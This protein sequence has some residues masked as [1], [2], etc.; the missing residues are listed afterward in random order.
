MRAGG[1]S[2][3]IGAAGVPDDPLGTIPALGAVVKRTRGVVVLHP[4]RPQYLP[5]M[6][7]T[8]DQADRLRESVHSRVRFFHGVKVRIDQRV[9]PADDPLYV[10]FDQSADALR[11]LAGVLHDRSI[12]R[13]RRPWEPGGE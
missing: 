8:P 6:G 4:A 12:V 9:V 11:R 1:W 10:P 2:P 7:L 3:P 5:A 13:E